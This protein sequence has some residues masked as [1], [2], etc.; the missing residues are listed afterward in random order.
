MT[1]MLFS[2]AVRWKNLVTLSLYRYLQRCIIDYA[3]EK[4]CLTSTVFR[5]CNPLIISFSL[6][7]LTAGN[8]IRLL[9]LFYS[10]T[11]TIF[12][13]H[14]NQQPVQLSLSA[15]TGGHA[16]RVSL[17]AT[18]FLPFP[19]YFHFLLI[20]FGHLFWGVA[21]KHPFLLLFL[22]ALRLNFLLKQLLYCIT[23]YSQPKNDLPLSNVH[24]F[25]YEILNMKK[26][27]GAILIL[28]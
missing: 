24:F 3:K 10:M 13:R 28:N 27:S 6:P 18:F 19:Y 9:C 23:E 7:A 12:P 11:L 21:P 1:L 15:I 25:N 5:S 17:P 14:S 4:P 22:V 26:P 2:G 8:S 16:I 20:T